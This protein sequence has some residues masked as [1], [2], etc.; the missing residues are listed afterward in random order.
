MRIGLMMMAAV[1]LALPARAAPVEEITVTANKSLRGIWRIDIPG[2]V[3]PR[4]HADVA[5]GPVG[6]FTDDTVVL[7][8]HSLLFGP[9]RQQLCRIGGDDALVAHCISFGHAEG[10]KVATH[11]DAFTLAWS[12]SARLRLVLTGTLQSADSFSARFIL[13]Q[14]R[15]SQSAPDK[16]SGTKVN[17]AATEDEAG[18]GFI[19]QGA[20]AG[21]A[22]GD[23]AMLMPGAP[24]VVPPTDLET[25]GRI[26][27]V[28]YIGQAP[29]MR[30]PQQ[31]PALEVYAV[32]FTNGERLCGLHVTHGV[33]DG[34]LCA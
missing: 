30:D 34:L 25:L 15:E 20:L 12:Q 18:I 23:T 31:R 13:E 11:G 9:P 8:D 26:Q 2:S 24:D 32:E 19:L 21:V 6:T 33:I 29:L 22:L 16:M 14:E 7:T 5:S 10:G 4:K 17:L 3:T 27:A 28:Y 1:M